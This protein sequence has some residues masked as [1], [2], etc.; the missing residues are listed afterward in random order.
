MTIDLNAEQEQVIRE[1]IRAGLLSAP[2]E[3]VTVGIEAIR[4]RLEEQ[5]ASRTTTDAEHWS[6][7]FHAWVHDHSTTT[8]LLTDE[9]ISRESIYGT[10]GL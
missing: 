7:E 8:P 3:V 6:Q 5:L 2:D 4:R 9:A 1:A 10:R